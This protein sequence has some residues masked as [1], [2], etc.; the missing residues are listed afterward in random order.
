MLG[1][2]VLVRFQVAR[3]QSP[4]SLVMEAGPAIGHVSVN[5]YSTPIMMMNRCYTVPES[6]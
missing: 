2:L 6:L 1:Y 5:D 3:S 4:S